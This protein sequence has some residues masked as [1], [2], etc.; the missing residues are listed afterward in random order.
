MMHLT[1]THGVLQVNP[2]FPNDI[3]ITKQLTSVMA[4][5]GPHLHFLHEALQSSGTQAV[6]M[7]QILGY[8]R[9]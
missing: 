7:N 6:E 9:N 3:A 8:N 2:Y 1:H 4:S 5:P